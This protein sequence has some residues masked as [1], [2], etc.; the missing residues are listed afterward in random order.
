M[1]GTQ[2]PNGLDIHLL[3]RVGG[4]A[5]MKAGKPG[6][7]VAELPKDGEEANEDDGAMG[8]FLVPRRGYSDW[9]SVYPAGVNGEFSDR[10]RKP[11]RAE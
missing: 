6:A 11:G 3:G 7:P 10:G 8:E 9:V 4:N 5:D 1:E 2:G